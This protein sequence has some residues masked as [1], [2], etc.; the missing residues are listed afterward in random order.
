MIKNKNN[1]G[2]ILTSL[3]LFEELNLTNLNIM[4]YSALK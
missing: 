1:L 2:L 3:C 4:I